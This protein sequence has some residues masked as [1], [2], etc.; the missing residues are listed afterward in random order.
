MQEAV[1]EIY[2]NKIVYK[3]EENSNTIYFSEILDVYLSDNNT[4][5]INAIDFNKNQTYFISF[6]GEKAENL[7]ILVDLF[8]LY[9]EKN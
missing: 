9:E 6:K 1:L 3:V 5:M 4:I 2:N 8:S 7:Y